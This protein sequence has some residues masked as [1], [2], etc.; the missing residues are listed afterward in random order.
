M[1]VREAMIRRKGEPTRTTLAKIGGLYIHEY[2]RVTS[3]LLPIDLFSLSGRAIH[4]ILSVC[5]LAESSAYLWRDSRQCV[6]E[7][8]R[9]VL[10]AMS[11]PR[12]QHAP[13][14]LSHA[15]NS[16]RYGG[17]CARRAIAKSV[18]CKRLRESWLSRPG[19]YAQQRSDLEVQAC[20][21]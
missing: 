11:S 2:R 18:C 20:K 19:P 7:F 3:S 13:R 15:E 12:H 16:G 5:G 8:C 9:V 14:D 17:R 21:L 1:H 4:D 6:H 10:G